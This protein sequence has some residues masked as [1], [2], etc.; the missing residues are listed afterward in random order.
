VAATNDSFA[1]GPG[2]A[3]DKRQFLPLGL[4]FS[5]FFVWVY[6][7]LGSPASV[8]RIMASKSTE[9]IRRSIFMLN[10]YNAMIYIPLVIIC[11]CA[12]ALIPVL[13]PGGKSDQIIPRLTLHVTDGIPGGSLLAGIVLTAPFGAVMATVSGYLVVIASGFV[14]DVYQR[15]IRPDATTTEIRRVTYL[16]MILVGAIAFA[17]NVK[18]VEYL[19]AIVVFS[20]TGAAATFVV[21]A[22]M[23]AYW[24][25]ATAPGAQAAM[26]VGGGTLIALYAIGFATPT[27]PMIGNMTRFRPYFLLGLDPIVWGLAASL[28]AGVVVSL[29][30][31]PP[32]SDRVA[33]LFDAAEER[34]ITE[35]R[36]AE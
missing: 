21:P 3:S 30:T 33:R 36:A 2:Y 5:F 35:H 25:R 10:T 4:A 18:P 7:G 17:A 9:H 27:D 34:S 28:V 1:F 6:S 22:L 31:W 29:S 19:Q 23:T 15:F 12:R 16:S 26:V 14:R 20:G 8:V 24:R 32:E 13:P 11:I